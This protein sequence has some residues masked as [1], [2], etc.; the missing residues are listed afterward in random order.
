MWARW[1]IGN[2]DLKATQPVHAV[3]DVGTKKVLTFE[4]MPSA[5]R[6][7]SAVAVV[8]SLNVMICLFRFSSKITDW[9]VLF[10]WILDGS[11]CSASAW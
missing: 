6:M 7:I 10:R 3:R 4:W 9:N 11:T 1:E 8:P 2:T 5:P